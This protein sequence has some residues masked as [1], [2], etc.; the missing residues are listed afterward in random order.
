MNK[1][2]IFKQDTLIIKDRIIQSKNS[3]MQMDNITRVWFGRVDANIPVFKLLA[4]LVVGIALTNSLTF[5]LGIFI[6][7]GDFAAIAY[8]VYLW[9]HYSLSFELSSGQIYAFTAM[10]NEFLEQSYEKVKE[11]MNNQTDKKAYEI[12][13][14]SC[15]IDIVSGNQGPVNINKVDNSVN[16]NINSNNTNSFNKDSFNNNVHYDLISSEIT[17]LLKLL[18]EQDNQMDVEILEVAKK[19]SDS[20]NKKGLLE[21]L[22][23]LSKQTLEFIKTT[24]SFITLAEFIS[25]FF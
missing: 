23:K 10:K 8:Y 15:Q 17:E 9:M 2:R 16:T 22:K 25:K 12:N 11:I 3:F 18:N 19:M 21:T 4:A 14:N 7:I 1:L 6:I 13:F 5:A 20:S 24:S